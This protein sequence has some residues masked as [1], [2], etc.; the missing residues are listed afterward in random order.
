MG[1][2]RSVALASTCDLHCNSHQT[3]PLPIS[4]NSDTLHRFSFILGRCAE[5]KRIIVIAF[6]TMPFP[7]RLGSTKSAATHMS[8]FIPTFQNHIRHFQL[9]DASAI[10]GQ[11]G[12]E[13]AH[14]G[15]R[16]SLLRRPRLISHNLALKICRISVSAGVVCPW[17][18]P[19]RLLGHGD[20]FSQKS[21]F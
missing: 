8:Q 7:A 17:D 15:V 4:C 10:C 21:G 3:T 6:E 11:A 12:H 19:T 1:S 20:L 9:C 2:A 13:K 14:R 18:Y 5:M 16:Q